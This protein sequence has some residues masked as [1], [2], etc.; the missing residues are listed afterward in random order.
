MKKCPLS[1]ITLTDEEC[2]NCIYKKD[3]D[4]NNSHNYI[5]PEFKG[6]K[7]IPRLSRDM[8]ISEKIDGTN[9]LVYIDESNN[10]FAGSKN[11]W[12]NDHED[13]HGF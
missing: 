7:K 6:F 11:I 10:I 4:C 9:G 3:I 8:I 12:L 5:L 13:N 1:G 2:I